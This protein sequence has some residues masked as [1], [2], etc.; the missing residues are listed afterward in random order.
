M[1]WKRW[2]YLTHRWLGIGMSLLIVMWFF[3]GVVMMYVGFPSLK[4]GERLAGLPALQ[5]GAIRISPVSLGDSS[6][7][8]AT[9]RLTTIIG[10]PAY[11]LEAVSGSRQI[12]FADNGELLSDIADAQALKAAA[13]Y[14][15]SLNG[16][17]SSTSDRQRPQPTLIEIL[18]MDQWTVSGSLHSH[19]PLYQIALHDDVDS[20]L[21]VSSQTAEVVR[22]T[23]RSERIWNW[24]GANLH[25]IYPVQLRRHAT[26]WHW[27]IVVL[28]LL[29]LVSI[30]TGAIVG[31]LRLRLRKRY[32]GKDIT[33]YKGY[34]KW[35]HLLGLGC[36]VFLTTYMFSG[37]MS[38][39]PWAVFTPAQSYSGLQQVYQGHPTNS[40][41][42]VL[43]SAL[44]DYLREHTDIK[45][46]QWQ[47][48]DGQT[49]LI[50]VKTPYEYQQIAV[51]IGHDI[52]KM[53]ESA[54]Q[55]AYKA[56]NSYVPGAQLVDTQQLNEYDLYYYS[57]HDSWR[58][59]PVLRLRFNNADQSWLHI[60]MKT[61]R[62]LDHKTRLHRIQRWLYNGL[63]S[64]DF[65]V[66]L[67]HRPLWDIVVIFLSIF[68]LAL[69]VTS[70][71]IG[72][73]RL[74]R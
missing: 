7:A 11:V 3:S 32:R 2:L 65:R 24:L 55:A 31:V 66:L 10:R 47:W 41:G 12:K 26:V 67:D 25:W 54:K 53:L 27:V 59:L 15:A 33:P 68:G 19:R 18:D 28:S 71:V 29:G 16:R 1:K 14:Q 69:S 51:P 39:N 74:S 63:H 42:E 44:Q 52:S 40:G 70:V 37:L 45:E 38:M 49:Y 34:M 57:H 6:D 72:W 20:H 36:V 30:L 8:I 50:A 58:P 60:D 5:A 73:R 23:H 17:E 64:L 61:G 48:I 4:T 62:L 43:F 21:Y 13:V 46:V 35:H 9:L 22:D 56:L